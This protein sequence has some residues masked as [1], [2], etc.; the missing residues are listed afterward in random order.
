MDWNSNNPVDG[1]GNILWLF[2]VISRF[3]NHVKLQ[4]AHGYDQN[5]ISKAVTIF[6]AGV[7]SVFFCGKGNP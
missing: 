3:C 5:D 6:L 4:L 7:R 1:V 2:L